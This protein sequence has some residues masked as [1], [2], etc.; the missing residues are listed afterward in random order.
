VRQYRAVLAPLGRL[1]AAVTRMAR[2]SLDQRLPTKGDAEFAQLADSFNH[3]AVQLDDLYH[4]LE[5]RVAE[6][7]KEL[8]RSERLAS[9]GYLAAG[10]AHE[11]NNPLGII[12]GYGERS[13]QHL[14]RGLDDATAARVEASLKVICDEAFS[15]EGHHRQAAVARP[16]GVGI[17][18]PRRRRNT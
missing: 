14:S 9:V 8:V 12:A 10:V 4:K 15:R 5:R 1:S 7:S 3:M 17:A 13:L 11:I 2:G 6:K 18:R 16:A